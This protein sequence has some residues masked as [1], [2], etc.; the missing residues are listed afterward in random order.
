MFSSP[1]KVVLSPCVGLCVL[2]ADGLCA[3]CFRTGDEIAGWSTMNDQQRLHL[4][5][6]VLPQREARRGDDA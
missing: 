1:Y 5:T 3:G 2:E 4:M 6:Q